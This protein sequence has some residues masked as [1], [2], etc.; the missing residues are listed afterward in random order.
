MFHYG[1]IGGSGGDRW[2]GKLHSRQLGRRL[3]CHLG[4]WQAHGP[5]D[6]L[7]PSC[8]ILVCIWLAV[9]QLLDVTTVLYD[10]S[11]LSSRREVWV[12][13]IT[14]T[15]TTQLV[16]VTVRLRVALQVPQPAADTNAAMSCM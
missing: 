3:D 4:R 14:N 5:G 10:L 8:A 2:G 11:T 16:Q 13:L 15:S 6:C 12:V 7:C 1:G 9:V